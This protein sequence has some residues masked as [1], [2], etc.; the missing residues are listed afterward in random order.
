MTIRTK[1]IPSKVIK[2]LESLKIPT[3]PKAGQKLK[4]APFQKDFIR[5][6]MD[7]AISVGVLSVGRGA[8]KSAISAGIA[9]GSVIGEWDEQPN[10]EVLIAAKTREQARVAWEYAQALALQLPDEIQTDLVFRQNPRLEIEYRNKGGGIIKAI[11]ADGKGILG[12]S[13]NLVIMDERGHWSDAKGDE[14]EH[15]LLSGLGKRSGKAL[16]ISTSASSDAHPF[17][18][19]LDEEQDGVYRQEHRAPNGCAA[20]D[21]DAIKAANPGAEH[22]IGASLDWLQ[23]QAKR[24]IS[25]GGST[26]TAWRLY[27]LNQRVAADTREM[28]LTTD[29]YLMCEVAID[30]L[31]P[32]SGPCV[33]GIDL[34]GSSSMSCASFYWPNTGRLEALGTFPNQPTLLDRGQVDGV[35]SRYV[36]MEDRKELSTLGD[37]T[38]PVAPWLIDV[39]NHVDREHIA[40]ITMDRYKQAEL[41]EAIDRAGIRAP[42]VWRGQGFR[43]GGEDAER[44]RRAVFDGDVK[45]APS[46]LLRSAFSDA[47]VI[48]DDAN[49]LK[50]TKLRSLG[51]IDAASAT[52]LAVAQGQRIIGR[53]MKKARAALWA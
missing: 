39:V 19:W 31:P 49:N 3:G 51:R 8:G 29:E 44:M 2:F 32:R 40:A 33:I 28:L 37:R 27:N 10:R 45:T 21:L 17:S 9:L 5:G 1:K 16:I 20:D 6:A 34:G 26:L 11:A 43:D 12:T 46:L 30:D 48:R 14:L 24:A 50:V 25:R 36:E 13:P 52:I 42:I 35:G 23:Q 41:G 22:G 15:A 4:L 18:K 38:V 47:V 7:P 53:G